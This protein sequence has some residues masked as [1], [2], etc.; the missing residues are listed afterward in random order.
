MSD[1]DPLYQLM[2]TSA[3][4]MSLAS[5]EQRQMMTADENT[6][7]PITGYGSHP[8]YSKQLK[9]QTQIFLQKWTVLSEA[10]GLAVTTNGQWFR[11]AQGAGSDLS[12]IY[13]MNVNGTAQVIAIEPSLNYITSRLLPD[14]SS[15]G[16]YP[17]FV[18]DAD[19][20]PLWLKSGKLCAVAL[21]DAIRD[22]VDSEYAGKVPLFVDDAGNV[23]VWLD[24]GKL[25]AVSLTDALREC[26]DTS[27]PS[28]VP[29]FV[30]DAG[31]VP[32]WLDQGKL[33]AVALAPNLVKDF[34]TTDQLA[35]TIARSTPYT[36][37][38]SLWRYR[39]KKAK[40]DLNIATEIRIGL[41]GDSW[42]EHN[43]ISQ[44]V[45]DYFYAKYGK[46]GDGWIQMNIDNPN[47]LNGISLVRSGWTVYDAS[48]WASNP[49]YPTSMDGQ[50]VFATGETATMTISNLFTKS[51]RIFYYDNLATF[52]YT[53]NGV[54]TT[55]TGAGTGVITSVNITGLDISVAT[56]IAIDLVGNTDTVVIYG[57]YAKGTGVGVEVDK[58]GNGG[59]TA[60]QYTKTLPYLP[61][62]ASVVDPDVL[63][64]IIGTND[65]RTSVSLQAFKDGLTAWVSKW[66]SV[67]PDSTII[68]VA[69]PQC[70]ASG[71]NPLSAFRDTMRE[72]AISLNVEFYS[73]YD[74]M[75]TTYA[76]ANAQGLWKDNLH[77]SNVGARFLL[78]QLNM[79]FLGD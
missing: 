13:Y 55:V 57:L 56:T 34:V 35:V 10:D 76:K 31:N 9:Q 43:T 61:Q 71:A 69:P 5:K 66:Q 60:P 26:V 77:L 54:T 65:Y 2:E 27:A 52:R 8:S 47:Q 63:L 79:R 14:I 23:P 59:I 17:L 15:P 19:N 22:V 70:N 74:F 41:S 30:D 1:M 18:D 67:I 78:N 42:T 48:T 37:G 73:L 25:G 38:K 6:D 51:V 75:D 21:D 28:K 46:A 11:V 16:Y 33:C 29:L 40:R 50:Y 24:K 68:L 53:V 44:V 45:A 49:P 39:G 62:T 12:F 32:V 4:D 7:V 36:A 3:N 64:L 72:V 20:V 58:M